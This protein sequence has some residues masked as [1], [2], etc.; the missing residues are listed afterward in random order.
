MI[1]ARENAQTFRQD[2]FPLFEED[3]K[4]TNPFSDKIDF[5][6]DVEDYLRHESS[7]N[8]LIVTAR[9][10]GV[11]AGYLGF[12]ATQSLHH[13]A[14]TARSCGL[15]VSKPYR[16]QKVALDLLKECLNLLKQAGIVKVQIGSGVKNDIGPLLKRVDPNFEKE[17]IVYGMI[18]A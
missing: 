4:E 12:L 13:K 18:L 14:P 16:G 10:N 11:L 2:A 6:I 7:G 1:I 15:F 9:E 17:E 3:W 5:S 8:L